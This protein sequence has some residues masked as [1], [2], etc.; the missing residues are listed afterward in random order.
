MRAV[1][2]HRGLADIGIR[3]EYWHSWL[4]RRVVRPS[5]TTATDGVSDEPAPRTRHAH[6]S[7]VRR[8]ATTETIVFVRFLLKLPSAC[9][10]TVSVVV[11]RQFLIAVEEVDVSLGC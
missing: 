8:P 6:R 2:G 11:V 1:L 3:R 5:K 7:S 4:L 9:A 10:V